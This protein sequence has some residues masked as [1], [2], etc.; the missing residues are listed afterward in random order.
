MVDLSLAEAN[1]GVAVLAAVSGYNLRTGQYWVR[2]V[3][4]E[5]SLK[6]RHRETLNCYDIAK[7]RT[8]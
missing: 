2:P 8:G 7:K 5:G 6:M 3:I 1:E 4:L